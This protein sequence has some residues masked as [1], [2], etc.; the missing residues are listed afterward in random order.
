MKASKH[1]KNIL[2]IALSLSV[3]LHLLGFYFLFPLELSPQEIKKPIKIKVVIQQENKI[4]PKK[5]PVVKPV[6]SQQTNPITSKP[7]QIARLV[8]NNTPKQ[9]K[10]SYSSAKLKNNSRLTGGIS[11]ASSI[12]E[13]HKI[14]S[15][16]PM[17]PR[18]KIIQ[19]EMITKANT[20]ISSISPVNINV[21]PQPPMRMQI[22]SIQPHAFARQIQPST[23]TPIQSHEAVKMSIAPGKAGPVKE[24]SHARMKTARTISTT[25]YT[26]MT[27]ANHQASKVVT[28][29]TQIRKFSQTNFS[30]ASH[31]QSIGVKIPTEETH[32]FSAP[33][34]SQG[35]GNSPL[36]NSESGAALEL[37]ASLNMRD[38]ASN[39][40]DDGSGEIH[41]IF[42]AQIWGKIE[43]QKYYPRIARRR[44][45][46]G[47][48]V[49]SF[50]IGE[51]GDL[52]DLTLLEA[53]SHKVL[54]EA[55]LTAVKNASPY[56]R[57]PEALKLQSMQFKLPITFIL[58]G[59]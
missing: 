44:G 30:P 16:T 10:Q 5:I 34:D 20:Q 24:T 59:P 57:I 40:S 12:R 45:Y 15:I 50:T 51:T 49:V 53:S 17:A 37:S 38:N 58:D 18:Q 36:S 33:S 47:K 54:D 55:A 3:L 43:E 41:K 56:P 52:R 21:N 13:L 25:K 2:Q 29:K 39:I 32:P 6:P 1:N 8:K 19:R 14:A 22:A 11:P 7:S 4:L 23:P 27:Q 28:A 26:R 46:Q 42:S 31:Q 35:S 48:P 9:S